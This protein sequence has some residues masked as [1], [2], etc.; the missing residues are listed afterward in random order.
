MDGDL[1]R[2]LLQAVLGLVV[3]HVCPHPVVRNQSHGPNLIG[4][5]S[6]KCRGA[7]EPVGKYHYLSYICTS[8]SD[9]TCLGKCRAKYKPLR[10]R[11][12]GSKSRLCC[13]MN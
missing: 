3:H 13:C 2:M 1:A 8:N 10:I 9:F 7:H 11:P 12:A 4:H 6:E 5:E